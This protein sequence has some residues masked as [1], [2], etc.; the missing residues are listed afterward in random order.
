MGR[1]RLPR[2]PGWQEIKTTPV[3]A[4]TNDLEILV[5]GD[6]SRNKVQ[7]LSANGYN[8]IQIRLPKN[9]DE[10]MKAAGYRPLREFQ[11]SAQKAQR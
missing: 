6:P 8:T 7:T 5:L 10:L 11:L 1:S 2:F 9:W 4:S 3:V